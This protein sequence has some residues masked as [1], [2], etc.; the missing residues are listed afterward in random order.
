M[1]TCY[2]YFLL[3]LCSPFSFVVYTHVLSCF[4]ATARWRIKVHIKCMQCNYT[5]WVYTAAGGKWNFWGERAAAEH[6]QRPCTADQR[7]ADSTLTPVRENCRRR[8]AAARRAAGRPGAL[9]NKPTIFRRDADVD[10]GDQHEI[11]ALHF[12]RAQA[13]DG[14]GGGVCGRVVQPPEYLH[15]FVTFCTPCIA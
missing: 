3:F 9:V 7:H 13:L 8:L 15:V 1:N 11:S 5:N 4:F 10:D 14:G 12:N 6:P 2:N